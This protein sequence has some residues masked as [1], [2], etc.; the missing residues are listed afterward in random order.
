MSFF[1]RNVIF[2][3]Q[4]KAP[5]ASRQPRKICFPPENAVFDQKKGACGNGPAGGKGFLTPNVIFDQKKGACGNGPAGGKWF[6]SKMPFLIKKRR[7]RQAARRRKMVFFPEKRYFGRKKSACG[8]PP[9]GG[10]KFRQNFQKTF[11]F[12]NFCPGPGGSIWL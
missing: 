8:K 6:W 12:S 5:A 9:V 1:T 10:K 3:Q 7:L 11:C 2:D 4:K